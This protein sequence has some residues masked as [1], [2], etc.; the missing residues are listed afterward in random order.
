MVKDP[1]AVTGQ[2]LHEV[3]AVCVNF[4][5]H[6]CNGSG[7][8]WSL[9]IELV[10]LRGEFQESLVRSLDRWLLEKVAWL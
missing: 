7:R 2:M 9:A 3:S 1:L 4:T 6:W 5:A 10:L 8:P